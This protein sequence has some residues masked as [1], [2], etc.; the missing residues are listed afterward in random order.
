MTFE[1]AKAKVEKIEAK[2]R[3]AR[4]EAAK[5]KAIATARATSKARQCADI[6][7]QLLL[8]KR[9]DVIEWV[10]KQLVRDKDK[11]TFT[12]WRASRGAAAKAASAPSQPIVDLKMP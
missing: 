2:L 9:V 8:E 5:Q 4:E 3:A 7:F 10:E 1:K 6:T 11:M 12:E